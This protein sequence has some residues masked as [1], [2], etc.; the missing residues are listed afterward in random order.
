LQNAREIEDF[1]TNLKS[2]SKEYSVLRSK[3]ERKMKRKAFLGMLFTLLLTSMFTAAFNIKG[4]STQASTLPTYSSLISNNP[5]VITPILDS[6]TTVMTSNTT[7]WDTASISSPFVLYDPN[8]GLYKMWYAAMSQ[9]TLIGPYTAYRCVIAYAESNDGL[10]WFN[11]QVVHDTGSPN[12]N[13]WFTGDPFVLKENGTYRMWHYDRWEWVAGDWSRYIA[14]MSSLNGISWPAFMSLGDQKVLSALGQTNPQGD[15][16]S[17]CTPSI[18]YQEGGG[19]VLWYSVADHYAPG[20]YGP[21]KIWRA[22]SSDG[23]SWSNRQLS[24][25]YISNTWE[26]AVNHPSV[27]KENNGTY[28]MFYEADGSFSSIG[29]A[30]SLDGVTWANRTQILK[31]SELGPNITSISTPV[32]FQDVDGNRY[33]YFT[34]YDGKAKMGR[35]Q[36]VSECLP[37]IEWSRTYEGVGDMCVLSIVQTMDGGYALGGFTNSYG[38]GDYDLWLVKTDGGGNVQWNRTYG[39]PDIDWCGSALET[40][41][42]GYALAGSSYYGGSHGLLVKTDEFGRMLWNKTYVGPHPG[43]ESLLYSAVQTS[44][45]GYA[46]AGS[47]YTGA[48]PRD[49]WLVKTDASGNVQWSNTYGGA[50]DDTAYSVIQTNDGGYALAGYT[51]SFGAGGSD[52][53]FVKTYPNG[54]LQRSMTYGGAGDDIARS[55]IQT[56]DGGYALAGYTNSCGCGGTDALL[57]KTD[58]SGHMDWNNTYG[59]GQDDHVYSLAQTSDGRYLMAG[60]TSQ[61]GTEGYYPWLVMANENGTM[62]WNMKCGGAATENA[63]DSVKPTSDGGFIACGESKPSASSDYETF[64]IELK[65]KEYTYE[66]RKMG[67]ELRNLNQHFIYHCPALA[68]LGNEFCAPTSAAVCLAWFAD[69]NPK[70]YSDLLKW[71]D[72]TLAAMELGDRMN[73]LQNHGTPTANLIKGLETYIT[74]YAGLGGKFTVEPVW[75]PSYQYVKNEFKKGQDVLIGIKDGDK[76]HF[77]VLRGMNE[78]PGRDGSYDVSF[79]NPKH[80]SFG[81]PGS[82]WTPQPGPNEDEL[83]S[84]C[85]LDGKKATKPKVHLMIEVCPQGDPLYNQT[86][87]G[88]AV[89]SN[90]HTYVIT[91]T[92][93]GEVYVNRG[94][95][96]GVTG[97][98]VYNTT[99]IVY[100]F[101]N[102]TVG[103]VNGTCFPV[104]GSVYIINGS[105]TLN[106]PS[107]PVHNVGVV[108]VQPFKTVIDR[109]FSLSVNVT[110]DNGGNQNETFYVTAY[111]NATLHQ[112]KSVTLTSGNFTTVTFTWSTTGFAM[113]NYTIGAYAWLVLGETYTADNSLSDGWVFVSILGDIN[114]DRKV[115]LYDVFNIALA[116]GSKVGDARYKPNLD[117]NGDGKIDLWDYFNA[118][119][120]FGKS[121]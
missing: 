109:G 6:F 39:T 52:F 20:S 75:N 41:D 62:L 53:Y 103:I 59:G 35:I 63:L 66:R 89:N 21:F 15:G 37:S 57:I 82:H 68:E 91:G 95:V 69:S 9:P 11:K 31:P 56:D 26:A 46:L 116:F 121:W 50:G 101:A 120:N 87:T 71:G 27:V 25:P 43:G 94:Q 23:I 38:A 51:T 106:M 73:T 83:S 16:N 92:D 40:R 10:T 58:V 22:T 114:G 76:G 85:D 33:L 48:G 4:G 49:F 117:L 74:Q 88:Y 84:D 119:L 96:F 13:F 115:N 111:A 60:D 19:Y 99:G 97:G 70:K 44:D 78:N 32:C 79:M 28:T 67:K 81:W 102:R 113:G 110:V 30:Q 34:Y 14:C 2:N 29:V 107:L 90:G 54:T 42:G 12:N 77:V 118:A 1:S 61:Y 98:T 86:L 8:A 47:A 7:T 55:V 45:E 108:D 36:L 105:E 93:F 5:D 64:S 80:G 72:L 24:L 65:H 112:R 104:T 18:I 3:G 100:G 17:V